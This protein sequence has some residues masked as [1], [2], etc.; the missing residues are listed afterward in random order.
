MKGAS[1]QVTNEWNVPDW[2]ES[3]QYPKPD[4]IDLAQWRWEFLRRSAEYR[5][6][7]EIYRKDTH[8][9]KIAIEGD[10]DD[11]TLYLPYYPEEHETQWEHIW[12]FIRKYGLPR[13]LDPRVSAPRYLN[14]H[15]VPF[16][17]DPEDNPEF[18]NTGVDIRS[19]PW[20]LQHPYLAWFDLSK[21]LRPQILHYVKALQYEK[22]IALDKLTHTSKSKGE[23]RKSFLQSERDKINAAI[24]GEH[25]DESN[26]RPPSKRNKKSRRDQWPKFL[27]VLD[28]RAMKKKPSWATI[29]NMVFPDKVD[30]SGQAR[31]A[32]K[33]AKTLWW[34]IDIERYPG[35]NLWME[36]AS[37]HDSDSI[38]PPLEAN[39]PLLLDWLNKLPPRLS[40]IIFSS[41][42]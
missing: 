38:L 17:A 20:K 32:A 29:G 37:W 28:A 39:Q 15:F 30:P 24:T 23:T 5:G 6:D 19:I 35:P 40:S 11:S 12:R 2:R 7:W 14:F 10:P 26:S 8:P 34:K 31:M 25:L 36:D 33:T 22:A 16:A 13:L 1:N 9:F 4:Q 42:S 41:L 3:S 21:P 18:R 27:R